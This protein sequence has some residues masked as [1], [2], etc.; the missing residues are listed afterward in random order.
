MGIFNFFNRQQNETAFRIYRINNIT[1]KIEVKRDPARY[2]WVISG[3]FRRPINMIYNSTNL[4]Y[5]TAEEDFFNEIE[6]L[7]RGIQKYPFS[8][9]RLVESLRIFCVEQINKY[10]RLIDVDIDAYVD[11]ALHIMVAIT[12]AM[13]QNPISEK[14]GFILRDELKLKIYEYFY[15]YIWVNNGSPA[16][17]VNLIKL[18]DLKS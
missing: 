2:D 9:D 18:S 10:G 7:L 11:D 1:V 14:D 16:S 8:K 13:R 5:Y 6:L 12:H 3:I 15:N 17:G 4:T